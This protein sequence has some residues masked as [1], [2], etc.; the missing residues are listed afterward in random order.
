MLARFFG[1]GARLIG[2]VAVTTTLAATPQQGA[3]ETL[4]DAMAGAY[5]TSGLLDQNR[6]LLRAADEDVAIAV[7]ALRPI[8]NF[9]GNY[10]PTYNKSRT[11]L[12]TTTL[13]SNPIFLGISLDL[14]L[15]DG[16]A[17][18]L[19]VEAAKETVLSTRQSL[20]SI[21]QSVLIRAV[22]A[23]MNV[24]LQLE[25]VSLRENNVRLL[26]EEL[27]A[28]QDR[29]EVGEVTRTDVALA[30][31]RLAAA[32]SNLASARGGLVNA[33]SEYVNA[34][35][36][37]AGDLEA[38][39]RLPTAPASVDAA[40]AVAVRNHPDILSAQFRVAAA[41]LLVQQ[42]A[43]AY[44]P[45][46]TLN[47]DVGVTE[48]PDIVNYNRNASIGLVLSQSIYSGGRLAAQ[49]RRAQANGDA[50]RGALLTA[51]KDIVQSVEDA[52]A[53]LRVANANLES[54]AERIRAAQVAFDGIREEATLGARTTIDVLTAEQDLLDAQ[55]RQIEATAEQYVAAYQLLQAQGLLTAERL[56]LPVQIYD[57][58]A[59]YN[60]AETAPAR[61]S[62]QGQELDR[63]LKALGKQ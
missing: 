26:D 3:A 1:N 47:G 49:T 28:T 57:P 61:L 45:T 10:T 39:P 6:A 22:A 33:R 19:G 23:Y 53:R 11:A 21:E 58:V 30:E 42:A 25:N 38:R 40:V 37:E 62:Q 24:V 20:L 12:G 31:S 27:R 14:L 56:G 44:G 8:L 41:D 9:V 50:A 36:R 5:N 32:R 35:G 63:V 43:A 52:F 51:R 29:F 34:V 46:V 2:A 60:L 17:S 13:R 18:R 15:F 54:T 16:G 4:T 7:S 55:T 48:N 59:Y